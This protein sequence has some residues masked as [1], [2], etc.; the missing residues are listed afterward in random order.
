MCLYTSVNIKCCINEY[1]YGYPLISEM[2]QQMLLEHSITAPQLIFKRLLLI[3]YEKLIKK[4][5]V[6]KPISSVL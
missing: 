2:E 1:D 6:I 3:Q 5:S 4:L